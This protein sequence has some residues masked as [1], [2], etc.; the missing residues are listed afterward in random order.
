M[1]NRENWLDVKSYLKYLEVVLQQDEQTV[2]RRREQLR[3]LLEW[4]DETPLWRA[5][6]LVKPTFP[7]YLST[8]RN[9]HRASRPAPSSLSSTC[10][11]AKRY[12]YWARAKW[13]H[14]YGSLSLSWVETIVP[15]RNRSMQTELRVHQYYSLEEIKKIAAL[16]PSS[17]RDKRDQAAMCFMWLSGMR[18]FAFVTL[19]IYCVDI[20]NMSV[21]QLPGEGVH[22]K[23]SKAAITSLYPVQE[24]L[25]VII[26]WDNRVRGALASTSMWYCALDQSGTELVP[27]FEAH[28]GRR[29]MVKEGIKNI[30]A[31]AGIDY[32][33]SHKLRHGNGVY[34]LKNVRDMAGLK[35]VS[36]NLM[37][38]SVTITDS[39]YGNLTSD[40]VH[41]V[42]S[43]L[44]PKDSPRD[45]ESNDDL[46][47]KL[48]ELLRQ[49]RN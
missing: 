40:D 47:R 31:L 42:I 45:S 21:S 9:D 5:S 3:H 35:S 33:S 4:A 37:H 32:K 46:I 16:E 6:H 49:Q 20:K 13:P 28:A 18:V 11:T 41:R 29:E 7:A 25:D 36:Q 39:I 27:L 22:T 38:S 10:N 48:E 1:I 17:L 19:P 23:N 26:L 43:Q 8:A 12:F 24:L 2:S 30:C 14:R 15:P 44:K 34:G